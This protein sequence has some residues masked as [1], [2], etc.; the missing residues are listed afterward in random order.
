[1]QY[2]DDC[3]FTPRK[4]FKAPSKK[5]GIFKGFIPAIPHSEE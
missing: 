3:V 1:M 2:R 5:V 4:E